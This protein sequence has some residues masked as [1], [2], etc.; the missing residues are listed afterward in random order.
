MKIPGDEATPDPPEGYRVTF[1]NFLDRGLAL[2]NHEFLRG[3]LF[4]YGI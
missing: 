2:P 3:L 4:V 1:V